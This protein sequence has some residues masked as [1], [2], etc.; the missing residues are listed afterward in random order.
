M[1]N[2]LMRFITHFGA[3]LLALCFVSTGALAVTV[4]SVTATS[5]YYKAGS[6]IPIAVNFSANVTV[7]GTPT[8]ALNLTGSPTASCQANSTPSTTVLCNYTV[9]AGQYVAALDYANTSALV[10]A[11]SSAIN[12]TTPAAATLTLPA[13]GGGSSLST[14][15]VTVDALAPALLPANIVVNNSVRP[16]TIRLTFSEEL[17]QNGLTTVGNYAVT[18]ASSNFLNNYRIA[19][20]S[21]TPTGTT[22]TVVTLTLAAVDPTDPAT[23]ITNADASAFIQLQITGG[24]TDLAGNTLSSSVLRASAAPTLDATA[25]TII[26]SKIRANNSVQPHTV[27]VS[28]SEPL[29]LSTA[30]ADVTKYTLTNNSGSITYKLASASQISPGVVLLTL[31]T[32]MPTD[33]T[34]YITNADINSHLKVSVSAGVTDVAGVAVSTSAVI[35]TGANPLPILN[36]NAPVMSGSLIIV[37]NTHV[38]ISF[39][40]KMSMTSATTVGNYTLSGNSGFSGT[41][42]GAALNNSGYEVLF[43]VPQLNALKTGDILS[44]TA[45]STLQNLEGVFMASNV[46]KFTVNVTPAPFFFPAVTRSPVKSITQSNPVTITGINA[47][48]AI[49]ITPNSDTS[50]LCSIAPVTT[51][52]FGAFSPCNPTSPLIVNNGDQI[53]LQLTSSALGSTTVSGGIIVG[54]VQ[55]I[56]SVT[57]S[58]P[59]T[60]LGSVSFNPLSTLVG[61]LLNPDPA[62]YISSNGLI[63][64][65]ADAAQPVNFMATAVPNTAILL[66]DGPAKTISLGGNTITAKSAVGTDA[67]LVT[68]SY[69]VDGVPN[70]ALLEFA[71][72]RATISYTGPAAPLL[73][74]QVGTGATAKQI[75][76]SA[77]TVGISRSTQVNLELQRNSDGTVIVS[78]SGGTINLRL[79]SAASTVASSDLPTPVFRNEVVSINTLGKI[80]SIKIGSIDGQ[81]GIVG[82]A[83]S[84]SAFPSNVK[85][86]VKI[87]NLNP[88]LDRIDSSQPLLQSLFDFVG[89]RTTLSQT[90]QK[91]YGEIPLLINQIPLYLIPYGDVTVN[92]SRPDGITLA[93]DGHFE[94]SRNGVVVKLT[95]AVSNLK[96]FSDVLALHNSTVSLAEDGAY[97]V[98]VGGN[99]LL[100][101]PDLVT[102]LTDSTN[103]EISFDSTGRYTF[104]SSK[105][106]QTLNPHF[107]D[108]AQLGN[109]ITALDPKSTLVDNLDGTVTAN[110]GGTKYKLTPQYQILSPIGGIPPIHRNDVWW[111]EADGLVYFKYATGAAQGFRV[112]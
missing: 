13:L 22:P 66:A 47:P 20:A 92:T 111:I 51:G 82:D 14:S 26:A 86:R 89:S 5:G 100:A 106:V 107:Y 17:A 53:K 62:L 65:P 18:S 76:I 59:A 81:A 60:I 15:N 50:L 7:T 95:T 103:N 24:L 93:S 68:K 84:M 45:A 94:V 1:T 21:A 58:G 61:T 67:I 85:S 83:I 79:A 77:S 48:S 78:L 32:A 52:I 109:I 41:P 102:S 34:T 96:T 54:G 80:T 101:K 104:I 108:I 112:Q 12:D 35:E 16:N 2:Q 10:L 69:S 74:M 30:I 57:T 98:S 87:P 71:A 38:K 31:Q 11:N 40:Q 27:T 3:R 23:F 99:T 105:N 97:E 91:T 44:I 63:V 110:V 8:L 36:T 25:P 88:P 46:A 55:S 19:S 37:D 72:G 49:S 6:V 90:S 29:A 33:T 39:N 28:F 56:F 43:T 70:T 9:L 64:L 42:P 4:T 73:S 75:L